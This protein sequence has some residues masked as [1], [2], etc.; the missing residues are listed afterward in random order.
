MMPELMLADSRRD[1]A[2]LAIFFAQ[3]GIRLQRRGIDMF[4]PAAAEA[5]REAES[6]GGYRD[7]GEYEG[8]AIN[9]AN[10]AAMRIRGY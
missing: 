10:C 5:D 2:W 1:A 8:E 4:F 6:L 3:A 9:L 7:C